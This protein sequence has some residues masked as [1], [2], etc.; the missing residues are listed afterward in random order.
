[1]TDQEMEEAVVNFTKWVLVVVAV[2][3]VV[4]IGYGVSL[5]L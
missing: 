5:L 4:V 2:L 1:M 3:F